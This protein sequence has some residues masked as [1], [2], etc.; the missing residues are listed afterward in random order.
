MEN[1]AQKVIHFNE[2]YILC[3]LQNI[4]APRKMNIAVPFHL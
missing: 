1:I 4:L 3:N 2:I